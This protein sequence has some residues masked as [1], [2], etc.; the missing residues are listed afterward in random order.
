M[1][2][3][4]VKND[5]NPILNV[6]NNLS[7]NLLENKPF[8]LN[9][10]LTDNLYKDFKFSKQTIEGYIA[11][12]QDILIYNEDFIKKIGEDE[13]KFNEIIGY[14]KSKLENLTLTEKTKSMSSLDSFLYKILGE[15]IS[16]IKTIKNLYKEILIDSLIDNDVINYEDFGKRFKE[17]IREK[18]EKIGFDDSVTIDLFIQNTVNDLLNN[19]KFRENLF[20][21]QKRIIALVG[22]LDLF[23]GDT[24]VSPINKLIKVDT[25]KLISGDGRYSF[26]TSYAKSYNQFSD[27]AEDGLDYVG[28]ISLAWL[29]NL[30]LSSGQYIGGKALITLF[31]RYKSDI[32][33]KAENGRILNANE[34]IAKCLKNIQKGNF[35]EKFTEY[36]RE[37]LKILADSILNLKESPDDLFKDKS[38]SIELRDTLTNTYAQ[39]YFTIDINGTVVEFKSA[40]DLVSDTNAYKARNNAN[41][42]VSNLQGN[43]DILDFV[44]IKSDQKYKGFEL[45]IGNEEKNPQPIR[46]FNNGSIENVPFILAT[47][48]TKNKFF[49]YLKTTKVDGETYVEI[50]TK[51]DKELTKKQKNAKETFLYVLNTFSGYKFSEDFINDPDI[52]YSGDAIF[53]SIKTT[54]SGNDYSNDS[55]LA[56]F[57]YLAYQTAFVA[58]VNSDNE[59]LNAIKNEATNIKNNNRGENIN[60][61]LFMSET[62]QLQA[63]DNWDVL[64]IIGNLTS[65][66]YGDNKSSIIRINKDKSLPKTRLRNVSNDHKA[67]SAKSLD[68]SGDGVLSYNIFSN[69]EALAQASQFLGATIDNEWVEA[70]KLPAKNRTEIEKKLYEFVFN[71]ILDDSSKQGL[72]PFYPITISDKTS[73]YFPTANL[74]K[75]DINGKSLKDVLYDSKYEQDGNLTA[76]NAILNKYIETIFGQ[77]HQIATTIYGDYDNLFNLKLALNKLAEG[78]F[79]DDEI[80]YFSSKSKEY[81]EIKLTDERSKFNFLS[82]LDSKFINILK[83]LQ[84]IPASRFEEYAEK[85]A[86]EQTKGDYEYKYPEFIDGLHYVRDGVNTYLLLQSLFYDKYKNSRDILDAQVILED[87]ILFRGFTGDAFRGEKIK[88]KNFKEEKIEI[89]SEIARDL[90]LDL[91]KRNYVNITLGLPSQYSGS[92]LDVSS[93]E[94]ALILDPE[95]NKSDYSK[96]KKL[97]E[98]ISRY[99]EKLAVTQA[100]R[101][102]PLSASII[103]PQFR[104]D[105]GV[106]RDMNLAI[107]EPVEITI[108]NYAGYEGEYEV[109]DGAVFMNPITTYMFNASLGSSKVLN[110]HL[111][112]FAE[113][114]N[115]KFG[116]AVLAKCAGFP[117]TNLVMRDSS[118]GPNSAQGIFKRMLNFKTEHINSIVKSVSKELEKSKKHRF[119]VSDFTQNSFFKNHNFENAVYN[120][121]Q[122]T[123]NEED[124]SYIIQYSEKIENRKPQIKEV[125]IPFENI[126][127]LYDIWEVL[128]GAFTESLDGIQNEASLELIYNGIANLKE[129]LEEE[130]NPE[131]VEDIR[132]KMVDLVAYPSAIKTGVSNGNS[133]T[134]QFVNDP[135]NFTTVD[136]GMG[137][138][139]GNFDH[140]TDDSDIA[141]PVQIISLISQGNYTYDQALV[142][143][144]DLA[145]SILY[146]YENL[147]INLTAENKEELFSSLQNLFINI[148]ENEQ[149]TSLS[150]LAKLK[151]LQENGKDLKNILEKYLPIS[152]PE[153]SNSL[154]SRIISI[155]NSSSIK[156]RLPGNMNVLH[157]AQSTIK[158]YTL[159]DPDSKE[160]KRVS[161]QEMIKKSLSD[162]SFKTDEELEGFILNANN[163]DLN[164]KSFQLFIGESYF[165]IK[166]ENNNPIEYEEVTIETIKDLREAKKAIAEGYIYRRHFQEDLQPNKVVLQ[167]KDSVG[168]IYS[169]FSLHNIAEMQDLFTIRDYINEN[170]LLSITE[171]FSPNNISNIE[172]ISTL[173]K[174]IVGTITT[175]RNILSIDTILGSLKQETDII[176]ERV[177]NNEEVNIAVYDEKG[178][179][180]LIPITVTGHENIAAEA[181]ISNTLANK[182][183]IKKE[184]TVSEVLQGNYMRNIVK[185]E[186]NNLDHI[187]KTIT[188]E[189]DFVLIKGNTGIKYSSNE[190]Y[191]ESAE[192]NDI[193]STFNIRKIGSKY[194][195]TDKSGTPIVEKRNDVKITYNRQLLVYIENNTN[196]Q[197]ITKEI[198]D[199]VISNTSDYSY[200]VTK[201]ELDP[202][203]GFKNNTDIEY[204]NKDGETGNSKAIDRIANKRL[205]AFKEYLKISSGRIPAQNMQSIMSMKVIGFTGNQSASMYVSPIQL[206]LQGSDLDID[207][208]FTFYKELSSTGKLIQWTPYFSSNDSVLKELIKLPIR[209]EFAPLN[210]KELVFDNNSELESVKDAFKQLRSLTRN[211]S[212]SSI[213]NLLNSENGVEVA[214]NLLEIITFYSNPENRTIALSTKL[215]ENELVA[216]LVNQHY[217]YNHG[218]IDLINKG[219]KNKIVYS[220]YYTLNDIRN[221]SRTM[222]PIGTDRSKRVLPKESNKPPKT[223]SNIEFWGDLTETN[224]VGKD[225]ISRTAIG[226]RSS[227]S[228]DSALKRNPNSSFNSRVGNKNRFTG[229]TIEK[230]TITYTYAFDKDNSNSYQ[231][232][233]KGY[234]TKVGDP[235]IS[236]LSK[237]E[238]KERS[239]NIKKIETLIKN[240]KQVTD[241]ELQELYAKE[242]NYMGDP[243]SVVSMLSEFITLSTDNAKELTLYKL[244]CD[245][246]MSTFYIYG[247]MMGIPYNELYKFMTQPLMLDFANYMKADLFNSKLEITDLA[248]GFNEFIK[249]LSNKDYERYNE[250]YSIGEEKS[251]EYP[252][253]KNF[254]KD[255]VAKD[256]KQIITQQQPVT[257]L[258]KSIGITG[259]IPATMTDFIIAKNNIER[260]YNK[261]VEEFSFKSKN[262]SIPKK[263]DLKTYLNDVKYRNN[264][265]EAYYQAGYT[266]HP[267]RIIYDNP[268]YRNIYKVMADIDAGFSNTFKYSILSSINTA[269][270]TFKKD[271]LKIDRAL[272]TM[273]TKF[274]LDHI[275]K[276]QIKFS[277]EKG[278][279]YYSK[280]DGKTVKNIVEKNNGLT[281]YLTTENANNFKLWVETS[282][283]NW[284][285]TTIKDN[286]FVERL[287]ITDYI[288]YDFAKNR[289]K[290]LSLGLDFSNPRVSETPEFDLLVSNYSKI[291]GNNSPI[292]RMNENNEKVY[293]T[294]DDVFKLYSY[295]VYNNKS[296]QNS[297]SKLYAATDPLIYKQITNPT[298]STEYNNFISRLDYEMA[299]LKTS[300]EKELL[301]EDYP[302]INNIL[303]KYKNYKFK[304]GLGMGSEK[305]IND[306]VTVCL[307]L[308][309][310]STFNTKLIPVLNRETGIYT[311]K[312]KTGFDEDGH[313]TF[314]EIFDYDFMLGNT[315]AAVLPIGLG[316][317]KRFKPKAKNKVINK[318]QDVV[319]IIKSNKKNLN[320][321]SEDIKNFELFEYNGKKYSLNDILVD[322]KINLS[323]K[324]I[325]DL[326]ETISLTEQNTIK[327]DC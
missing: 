242:V 132:K 223:P 66:Y 108:P 188:D 103:T 202:E 149:N 273:M 23:M 300:G 237:E 17:K 51:N 196:N 327:L 252:I 55:K 285:K 184:V 104:G 232:K 64:K 46:Y 307:N 84:Q 235:K 275:S 100:K 250:L 291:A 29:D 274:F 290:S 173:G 4:C 70:D 174:R 298:I 90:T 107:I 48:K 256:I 121:E 41:S 305:V 148:Y 125:K 265:D 68:E 302:I 32:S 8:K 304:D 115:K 301:L 217:L 151:R 205:E 181:I 45:R 320:S 58:K 13:N 67:I 31:N 26:D 77:A 183:G 27:E 221:L 160:Y 228:I 123:V 314:S 215:E 212:V 322:K 53:N 24:T 176:A 79:S 283:K 210:A 57:L 203:D 101:A 311:L 2:E 126:T 271:L 152:S 266:I 93:E 25:N 277:F 325:I 166:F 113:A 289:R 190:N 164:L 82:K 146:T 211:F 81:T 267:Y 138:I 249:S 234:E 186:I 295:I 94:I 154:F 128:G 159:Y 272:N 140:V 139:Q 244:N 264:I 319:N 89:T 233:T 74:S 131:I 171:L 200:V 6:A 95:T 170:K 260:H 60:Y 180:Q 207:K 287:S 91:L 161:R 69:E 240:G 142:L 263:L 199:T 197:N 220:L 1:T 20:L 86:D 246:T 49:N 195:Y 185:N 296:A 282:F 241:S 204:L 230:P 33:K 279:N 262:G 147:G 18:L 213:I 112:L 297:F 137:G 158:Y 247:I 292:Y 163:T 122:I 254:I 312:E 117:I 62:Q 43:S 30:K 37:T 136:F 206:Y 193:T 276:Q 83:K 251:K 178:N 216:Q 120:L 323:E 80:N 299:K 129:N 191:K 294:I 16:E 224:M 175:N 280:K 144:D 257:F 324:N 47:N 179:A 141:S 133:L 269:E 56:A 239:E 238:I 28:E 124:H 134:E 34:F 236:F 261:T 245:P 97:I 286:F 3:I 143:H 52:K 308:Y 54:V 111:K 315:E 65:T 268:H 130:Y 177:F 310:D 15:N 19:E 99:E 278:Y 42:H 255:N 167:G 145:N 72:L 78:Y 106:G 318:T 214:K 293:L 76:F 155:I 208:S 219:L 258:A 169:N 303:T 227:F 231:I 63:C 44:T 189:N 194:F 157:P 156:Q 118:S 50:F 40:T 172:V 209:S 313:L 150:N 119:P 35:S 75:I 218:N 162:D 98:K 10:I 153:V 7:D 59:L 5:I 259:G 96:R 73:F 168:N 110:E 222:D 9:S 21:D 281:F 11:K 321:L 165:K 102:V 71:G 105:K 22:G 39:D 85:Y 127:S 88:G 316:V 225:N 306:L 192:L 253:T 226:S 201:Y 229:K 270:T 248:Y 87:N 61:K 92:K 14:I 116:S 326:L 114:Y 317:D 182:L 36:E 187:I 38:L 12:V 198:V 135:L 309:K 243:D 284:L 288:N 109:T